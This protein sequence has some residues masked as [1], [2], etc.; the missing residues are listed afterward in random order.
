MIIV[1]VSYVAIPNFSD[2]D[3]WLRQLNFFT[4]QIEAMKP[5]GTIKSVHMINTSAVLLRN[6]IE[7]HFVKTKP[8]DRVFPYFINAYIAR[9]LPDV[10]IVHGLLFPWSVIG[11]RV[12]LAKRGKIIAIHHAEKP[13]RFPKSLLQKLADKLIDSYCFSAK[14]LGQMWVDRKQ[15]RSLSKVHEVM[16]VT[17]VFH[18]TDETLI[19]AKLKKYIWVGRMDENKD[20]VTLLKAF[21]I[22]SKEEPA[23]ILLM[24]CKG[25]VVLPAVDRI[26]GSNPS[27][28]EK[29]V[30]MSNVPH[31]DLMM[32]FNKAAFIISTSHYEGGGLSVCEGM[33]CG[34]IPILSNIPSFRMMTADW[35]I[36][37]MFS[38]GD[39]EG[40]V[41]ALRNS[42]T[43][44]ISEE[45]RKTLE[46][47]KKNLSADAISRKIMDVINS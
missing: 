46:Q 21:A 25:D 35:K 15:I 37:L 14:G 12:A 39:V 45:Q 42:V 19:G 32:W 33:S 44:N 47:F 31:D 22:F 26:L 4:L 10:V 9:L 23:A 28:S 43:L 2:P 24:I 16:E 5:Y 17:S 29:V 11:L 6:G 34:C 27:L 13:L 20:P 40:L 41:R 18:P 8:W 1:H 38:P 7:Y 30:I 36:G 3:A